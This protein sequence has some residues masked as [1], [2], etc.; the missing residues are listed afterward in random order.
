MQYWCEY[1][2][3]RLNNDEVTTHCKGCVV[4][5]MQCWCKYSLKRLH[6]TFV[7][8]LSDLTIAWE[9]YK[10]RRWWHENSL[11]AYTGRHRQSLEVA[12]MDLVRLLLCWCE[13]SLQ[14][15]NNDEVTTHCK[16]CIRICVLWF[17]CWSDI[18]L[19]SV[20]TYKAYVVC[21]LICP[22]PRCRCWKLLERCL[23]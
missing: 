23:H 5:S 4:R 16:G 11:K 15:L 3:K 19:K 10:A 14:S 17:L 6:F 9:A 13:Y 8:P 12:T 7:V 22:L 20:R 18:T 1:T 2:L 21:P